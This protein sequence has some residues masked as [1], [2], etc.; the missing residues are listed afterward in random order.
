MDEKDLTNTMA[1][2]ERYRDSYWLKK[3]PILQDR[4]LWRAQAFR[5]MVH[6]LPGDTVLELG[7][8]LGLFT[9]KLL[10]VS[11]SEVKITAAR[12]NQDLQPGEEPN[13]SVDH[14]YLTSFPSKLAGKKFKYIV[15]MDLLDRAHCSWL[16]QNVYE[17]LLPGGEVVFFESNPWNPVL[18]LRRFAGRLVG[19]KDPRHLVNRPLLYELI[20][21]IGFIRVFAIFNDFVYSP[22]TPSLIWFLRNLSIMLENMPLIQ[23]LSGAIIIHAQKPPRI[24]QRPKVS[25]T[26]HKELN[27]SIS[28]VIP[29]YNEEMNIVSLVEGLFDHY[30]DYIYEII[31]VDD[32]SQ[33]GTRDKIKD[34]ASKYTRVKPVFRSPPNGVGFALA[35]GFKAATGRYI[36]SM[37]CDF[38]HLLPEFRDMFDSLIVGYDIVVGSRFSR[39]SILLNYPF[40]K[41]L[42]N[43]LFHIFVSLILLSRCRD[44]TNNL[45]IMKIE[46]ARN[47]NLTQQGFAVNAETGIQP[48]LMGYSLK[49]VPISWINRTPDMGVSSFRVLHVGGGY[50]KVLFRAAL[51]KFFNL[52]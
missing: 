21:E 38:K 32:N 27:N 52:T 16:L 51:K 7:S 37:D 25:L 5:H 30:S 3:D 36:L 23:T 46:V 39:H 26:M 12:F 14:L 28:I 50:I 42:A 11:K 6:L 20:S 18:K 22:L 31:T 34:L 24:I 29:C 17:F 19:K 40:F 15:S 4:L 44:L 13:P 43:R 33:D 8:G 10:H 45:K 49:E 47:L 2:R 41:I 1:I 48:L 35:D 9:E